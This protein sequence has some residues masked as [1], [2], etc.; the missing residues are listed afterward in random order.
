MDTSLYK[1]MGVHSGTVVNEHLFGMPSGWKQQTGSDRTHSD[2]T[3]IKFG[4]EK[5]KPNRAYYADG[6][7][8][9]V[10]PS[11]ISVAS[12]KRRKRS[13]KLKRIFGAK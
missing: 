9:S 13:D 3:C 7:E 2:K 12:Q 10:E 5:D 4:S 1:R 11:G 6:G 8:V